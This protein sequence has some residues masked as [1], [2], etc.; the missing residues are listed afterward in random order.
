MAKQSFIPDIDESEKHNCWAMYMGGFEVAEILKEFPG[1]FESTLRAWITR[2]GWAAKR[3]AIRVARRKKNP[4]E[5]SA[6]AKILDPNKREDNIQRFKE[7]AG[8]IAVKDI[9]HWAS[10]EPE[11]RLE[12]AAPIAS[13]NGVHR[14]NL[15]LDKEVEQSRGH[16][17][18]NFLTM[19]AEKAVKV[20]D[21]VEIEQ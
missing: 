2:D 13:L 20:I 16:I 8:E 1:L 9:E 17:N 10:L 5:E 14:K 11:K 19:P 21:A 18:I 4:P 12:V 7:K 15:E 3:E 6:L